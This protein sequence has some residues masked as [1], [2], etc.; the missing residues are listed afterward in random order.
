MNSPQQT[1]QVLTNLLEVMRQ[2]KVESISIKQLEQI[3]ERL[4]R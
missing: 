1:R 2:L 3:I 4:N